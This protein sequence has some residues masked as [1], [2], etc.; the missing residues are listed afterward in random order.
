M[1]LLKL[2]SINEILLRW[3]KSAAISMNIQLIDEN[4]GGLL[5]GQLHMVQGV[6]GSGKTW[7]CFHAIDCL[8]RKI[9]DAQVLYSDFQGHVRIPNLKKIISSS[10]QL[11]QITFYQPT[12]LLEQIIFFRN[13]VEKDKTFYDLIILD[14]IFGPPLDFIHCLRESKMWGKQIFSYLF[15]LGQLARKNRIPILLTNYLTQDGD[16]SSSNTISQPHWKAFLEPLVPID[17]IIEKVEGY[18][19]IEVKLFQEPLGQ[20]D[21]VLIP[22]KS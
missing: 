20:T 6:P 12:S 8:F 15:D 10:N 14:T 11:D 17:F 3:D 13:L 4:V 1:M 16:I 9:T 5:P 7:F 18:F 22:S 21:F 2:T 19:T